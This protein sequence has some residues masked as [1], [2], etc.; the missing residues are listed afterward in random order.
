MAISE[1]QQSQT[2]NWNP[3]N[4]GW[5]AGIWEGEGSILFLEKT[6][7]PQLSITSTDKDVIEK[8]KRIC[9]T[10]SI[11][12]REPRG[13]GKKYQYQYRTAGFQNVQALVAAFWNHLGERRRGQC[14]KALIAARSRG[15]GGK[16]RSMLRIKDHKYNLC[17]HDATEENTYTNQ[18]TKRTFC[19]ICRKRYMSEYFKNRQ[20]KEK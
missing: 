20:K 17:G 3:S 12:G 19:K 9:G 8:F 5:A 11:G 4:I 14:E 6:G 18:K 13:L 16:A 1:I 15:L 10:G 7:S 2:V